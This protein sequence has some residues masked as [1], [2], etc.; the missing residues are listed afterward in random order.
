MADKDINQKIESLL[1]TH[2][3]KDFE[4]ACKLIYEAYAIRISMFVQSF[5]KNTT[6]AQDVMQNVWIK[7]FSNLRKFKGN[8]ALYTWI[9]RIAYNECINWKK[10][11]DFEKFAEYESS[12]ILKTSYHEEEID[13]SK[14]TEW[15]DEAIAT[16]PP[17]QRAVFLMRYYDEL[18]YDKISEITGISEG[19]LK[20]SFHHAMVKVEKYLIDKLN[21]DR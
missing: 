19:S 15:F 18:P 13:F 16:L 14:A 8:S 7:V 17:R 5:L 10:S 6:D 21:E 12:E 2:S 3:R 9:Y 11:K 20:A 1:N 4:L